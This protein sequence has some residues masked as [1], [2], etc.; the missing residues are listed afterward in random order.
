MTAM[1][2]GCVTQEG[3]SPLRNMDRPPVSFLAGLSVLLLLRPASGLA[4]EGPASARLPDS[5]GSLCSPRSGAACSWPSGCLP[6]HAAELPTLRASAPGSCLAAALQHAQPLWRLSRCSRA[7]QQHCVALQACPRNRNLAADASGPEVG[8]IPR[9][10]ATAQACECSVPGTCARSSAA[11]LRPPGRPARQKAAAGGLSQ[12]QRGQ[13]QAGRCWGALSAGHPR[14][15]ARRGPQRLWQDPGQGMARLAGECWTCG[16]CA[17]PPSWPCQAAPAGTLFEVRMRDEGPTV[18]HRA[19]QL[20]ACVCSSLEDLLRP[21]ELAHARSSAVILGSMAT[22]WPEK[23]VVTAERPAE[24]GT[25]R[26][27]P[28]EERS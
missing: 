21:W 22:E 19:M 12:Q 1:L 3:C 8:L 14:G 23:P 9:H 6:C 7:H 24:Q 25:K 28:P 10:A 15:P 5:P 18:R 2:A 16:P 13:R 17:W 20:V 4:L 27:S 26:G 11:H